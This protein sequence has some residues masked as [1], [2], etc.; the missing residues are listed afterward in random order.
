MRT[1][2]HMSI[3]HE[4]LKKAQNN[5]GTESSQPLSAVPL[6]PPPQPTSPEKK[7]MHSLPTPIFILLV[8]LLCALFTFFYSTAKPQ[9]TLVHS[10]SQEKIVHPLFS[11]SRL[12]SP[13]TGQALMLSGTIMSGKESLALINDQI[14]KT[15]DSINE[16]KVLSITDGKVEILSGRE[17]I[18]LTTRD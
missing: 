15:G 14:V 17:T 9:K 12:L 6:S 7:D 5:L 18:V 8:I 2:G 10:K 16:K 1:G 13:P 3:I 11:Q 4:A